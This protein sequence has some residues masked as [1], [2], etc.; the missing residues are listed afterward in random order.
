VSGIKSS[1]ALSFS[2]ADRRR[3]SPA[4]VLLLVAALAGACGGSGGTA[5]TATSVSTQPTP[6]A[7]SSTTTSTTSATTSTT[8][9]DEVRA[10]VEDD[11]LA[12]QQAYEELAT[13]EPDPDAD[14]LER[15]LEEPALGGFRQQLLDWQSRGLVLHVPAD[16]V[17]RRAVEVVSATP[18]EATLVDCLVDDR[19]L[20]DARSGAV[21]PETRGA[22]TYLS[23]VQLVHVDGRWQVEEGVTEQRWDGAVPDC[24]GA[25]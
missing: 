21:V 8:S 23:T 3:Q 4:V 18:D 20:A 2:R 22:A 10:E 12:W 24:G 1:R 25:V 15:W 9:G 13:T 19:E 11:F 7:D 16:S 17:T 14:E 6:T 5:S